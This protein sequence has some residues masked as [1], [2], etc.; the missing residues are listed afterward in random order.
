VLG[1]GVGGLSAAHEL[2]ERFFPGL[3]RHVPDTMSRI[4]F[5]PARA[6]A[7]KLRLPARPPLRVTASGGLQPVGLAGRLVTRP[8]PRRTR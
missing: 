1:G 6:L 3:C 7:R 5:E 4:P 8:R 2:V